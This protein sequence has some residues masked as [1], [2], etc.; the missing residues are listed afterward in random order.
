MIVAGDIGGTN[1]RLATFDVQAGHLL[2]V[3]ELVYPSRSAPDLETI[4]RRF[5]EEARPAATAVAL[6]SSTTITASGT[7]TSLPFTGGN[8]GAAIIAGLV[9]VAAGLG[10][11]RRA[12][13]HPPPTLVRS[14]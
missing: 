4:A 12:P 8:S 10:L 11:T 14:C 5:V 13:R 1:A 7:D 3:K 2:L 6:G 9:L